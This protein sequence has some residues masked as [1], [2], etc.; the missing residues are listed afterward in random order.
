MPFL[1]AIPRTVTKPTSEPSEMTPPG[2]PE[3]TGK[4]EFLEEAGQPPVKAIASG[5]E[6]AVLALATI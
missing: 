6:R 1:A 2:R 5:M 3:G 4:G